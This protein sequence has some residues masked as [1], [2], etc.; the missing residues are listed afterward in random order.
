MLHTHFISGLPALY[1]P[2]RD[3][4]HWVPKMSERRPGHMYL[5]SYKFEYIPGQRSHI[6]SRLLSP[7]TK[8]TPPCR[9]QNLLLQDYLPGPQLAQSGEHSPAVC[10]ICSHNVVVVIQVVPGPQLAQSG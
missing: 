3:M 4:C 9:V 7:W 10:R 5:C 2:H 8:F 1:A 6:P